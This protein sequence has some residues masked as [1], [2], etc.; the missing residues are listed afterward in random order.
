VARPTRQYHHG[1]LKEAVVEAAIAEIERVGPA[2]LSMREIARRAGVSHAAPAHHFGDKAGIFTAIA[3]EGYR[4]IEKA[5]REAAVGPDALVLGGLAYV[6]FALTNRAHFEVMFR[7]DLY[8]A[9]D[10]DLVAARDAA[11]DVLFCAVERALGNND[12]VETLATVTAA[13]SQAHGFAVLWINGNLPAALTDDPQRVAE[14]AATGIIRLGT[15][16]QHQI[17]GALAALQAAPV[18]SPP[19][20]AS[21]TRR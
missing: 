4:R 16:T 10:P 2:A 1:G 15:I 12:P 9:D 6:T 14:L 19:A 3:T 5:T 11:F 21:R 13:W 7:P 8:R 17:T 18:A 20:R